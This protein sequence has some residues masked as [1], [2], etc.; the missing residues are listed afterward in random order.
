MKEII[1]INLI[2]ITSL[3]RVLKFI[4]KNEKVFV[5]KKK[6]CKNILKPLLLNSFCGEIQTSILMALSVRNFLED[7]E[8]KNFIT[9]GE[10]TPMYRP[11]YFYVKKLRN[12]PKI[13]T[14]QHGQGNSLFNFSKKEE[15]SLNSNLAGT[16][17]SPSPDKYFVQG[18]NFYKNIKKFYRGT[19]KIIGSPRYDNIV[20]KEKN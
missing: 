6:N 13:T 18:E 20:L 8:F 16:E 15:F 11:T 5:I 10:F 3:F 2:A 19:V 7:K 9:Y 12:K 4:K 17:Y 1:R 14:F